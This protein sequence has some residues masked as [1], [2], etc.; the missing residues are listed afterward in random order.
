MP[1]SRGCQWRAKEANT[2]PGAEVKT[3]FTILEWWLEEICDKLDVL[4]ISINR[5][6]EDEIRREIFDHESPLL[7]KALQII[8][9]QI[10]NDSVEE[11]GGFDHTVKL[12]KP[13]QNN[14]GK[15]C[16]I[17]LTYMHWSWVSFVVIT[18]RCQ[19]NRF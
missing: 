11:D 1:K 2:I 5:K 13:R 9:G 7:D 12:W 16:K 18:S 8:D 4:G 3:R 14:W 17:F 10:C 19:Y 15:S 6:K